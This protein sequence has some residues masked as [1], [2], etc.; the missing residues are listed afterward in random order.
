[1]RLDR[2]YMTI[3]NF[4]ADSDGNVI[5]VEWS[6]DWTHPRFPGTTVKSGFVT[7]LSSSDPTDFVNIENLNKEILCDWVNAVEDER[8]DTIFE[9]S[10]LDHM[11]HQHKLDQCQTFYLGT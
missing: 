8:L 7:E 4:K 5:F 6:Y 2:D 11:T 3:N 10:I 9:R 1:M